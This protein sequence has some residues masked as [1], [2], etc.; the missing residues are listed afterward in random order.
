MLNNELMYLNHFDDDFKKYLLND[1]SH[2]D[3]G[4]SNL[5]E[6]INSIEVLCTMN[7]CQGALISEEK[8]NHCPIS[9]VDFYVLHHQY[10]VANKLF[11]ELTHK[12]GS[13]LDCRISYEADFNLTDDD[14][15]EDNGLVNLRYTIEIP[16]P[17]NIINIEKLYEEIVSEVKKFSKRYKMLNY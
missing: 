13:I 9:Y 4:I 14:V 7:C 12:F 10:H 2:I 11:V 1:G 8:F 3:D 5:V 6:A 16:E 17:E 15:S